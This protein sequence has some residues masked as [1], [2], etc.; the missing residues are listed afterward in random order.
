MRESPVE[1]D[2]IGAFDLRYQLS[3]DARN[4]YHRTREWM[5]HRQLSRPSVFVEG[6]YVLQPEELT[7]LF[8][9]S[10][11]ACEIAGLH[12]RIVSYGHLLLLVDLARVDELLDGPSPKEP[13]DKNVTSLPEAICAVY[14]L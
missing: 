1:I 8:L 12:A 6:E 4:K 9:V 10:G 3:N 13:V 14:R 2:D 11:Y 5:P 7:L